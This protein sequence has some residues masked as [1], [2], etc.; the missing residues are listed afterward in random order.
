VWRASIAAMLAGAVA[1]T[2]GAT[3]GCGADTSGDS[4]HNGLETAA[5]P[6]AEPA[7]PAPLT[8][9]AVA[10]AAGAGRQAVSIDTNLVVDND[11]TVTARM[12]GTVGKIFVDRGSR[13]HTGD[14]LLELVNRDLTL[15]LRRAEIALQQK[16]SDFE[17]TRQLHKERTVPESLFEESQL[18]QERARVEVE[19][20]REDLEKSTVR[21]PFDGVIVDRFARLGQKVIEDD[22]TPLFRLTTLS[23]LLARLYLTE[24]L[25]QS[26]RRGDRVEVV[27][28][29][30]PSLTATGTIQWISPAIDA[31]SGTTLAI[32]TLPGGGST[33]LSPG[34]GVTVVLH[35]ASS[36][37]PA[38]LIPAAALERRA[39]D[40]SGRE[41]RVEV[42][43]NGARSWR[44]VRLGE[45]HGDQIEVLDGLA[46]GDRVA[47]L[48]PAGGP[49][50]V[51]R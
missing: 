36:G 25:A 30:Q 21:A 20:A 28:R 39:Q 6:Q 14:P 2:G 29:Y 23:P 15:L 42:I 31:P 8:A 5:A 37:R 46:P 22:S 27:S 34:M 47:V 11:I 41:A 32:V 44:S 18:A 45:M 9:V 33:P 49:G 13:V 40:P 24:D 3:L 38:V 17:R 51:N 26:L 10:S 43:E 50:E 1:I 19:M 7:D 35:P 16:T 4:P 12:G 48:P